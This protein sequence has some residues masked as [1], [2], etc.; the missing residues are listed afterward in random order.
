MRW[1]WSLIPV[2]ICAA[3]CTLRVATESGDGSAMLDYFLSD[4]DA[5]VYLCGK[6]KCAPAVALDLVTVKCQDAG[7]GVSLCLVEPKALGRNMFTGVLTKI[8]GKSVVP[9]FIFFG[10][11]VG[12]DKSSTRGVKNVRGREIGEDGEVM[13]SMFCWDGEFYT[14]KCE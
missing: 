3:S 10:S 2:A 4:N 5:R 1:Y 7:N 11:G 13:D 12:L 6:E 9:Q 14:T 8:P